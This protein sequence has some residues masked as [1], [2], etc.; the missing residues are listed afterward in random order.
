MDTVRREAP[1]DIEGRSWPHEPELKRRPTPSHAMWGA[2]PRTFAMFDE[3]RDPD[4]AWAILM[5]LAK[6]EEGMRFCKVFFGALWA[7]SFST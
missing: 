5:R 3:M 7:R 4:P 6:S 2:E 1:E